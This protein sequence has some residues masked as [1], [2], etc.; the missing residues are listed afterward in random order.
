MLALCYIWQA[1]AEY[2]RR[3]CGTFRHFAEL[4][5]YPPPLLVS[6]TK[7]YVKCGLYLL[8]VCMMNNRFY[9]YYYSELSF[10]TLA[11]PT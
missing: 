9:Y 2:Q 11:S 7:L 1:V 5:L 10:L 8:L 4:P 3:R 6:D